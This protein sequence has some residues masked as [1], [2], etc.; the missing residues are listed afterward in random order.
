MAT[1]QLLLDRIGGPA[2]LDL[3]VEK[4]CEKNVAHTEIAKVRLGLNLI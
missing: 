4:F 3:A 2:A 1:K